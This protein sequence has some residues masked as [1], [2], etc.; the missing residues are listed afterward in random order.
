MSI[1]VTGGAG[2]IGSNFVLDWFQESS[3]PVV[4]LDKLTYA[5]NPENL[6]SL[7]GNQAHKLVQGDIGDV[8]LVSRLLGEHKPRAVLNFAA[9]SHVDRSIHGPG[10]F[11]Q[12]NIVG[13]FHLLEA[14]RA[15]WNT[16]PDVERAAFRFLH[17]STDEVY[18]SLEK[19]DPAFSET[20]RYEP[21]SPYSASKA[22]SDHLVRAYHHTYGLPVLTTNCSNNYGP[23]HFPEKLIPLVIHNALAGK[24]LPIYGDGQQIR[25]WLYVKDHCSAIRRVLA[26]G[27]LGETYN[28]GGW[29][30]K[31]NLEV[32]HTLCA[33]LDELSPRAD[34][35]SYKNQITFVKDRPGHD[36]R[37]AIDASRLERELGWK[38]AETFDTGIRKTVQW[39]LQN[40][41]WVANITSGAYRDW[42]TTQYSV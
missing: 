13:T 33:L 36:Q 14:V 22:A 42:V 20:N 28:V 21:N 31:A 7:K 5:G 35:Q 30:E 18:G 24:P 6:A 15:Y 40:Q 4:T 16:L 9:E 2:F 23:Y 38:P 27:Q 8:E 10:E 39:Y 12:T 41:D 11:I 1:I 29:N 37:Y 25:D 34:G 32:V 3:E 19:D 17:V 26:D